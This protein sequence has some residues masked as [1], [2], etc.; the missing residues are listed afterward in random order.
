M[1]IEYFSEQGVHHIDTEGGKT[2][3]ITDAEHD[4]IMSD[5][6]ELIRRKSR[7]HPITF[8]DE[9]P[10]NLA[11]L[12]AMIAKIKHAKREERQGIAAASVCA[13]IAEKLSYNNYLQVGKHEDHLTGYWAAFRVEQASFDKIKWVNCGHGHTPE[14]AI[15]NAH[16]LG[17]GLE[18]ATPSSE[19]NR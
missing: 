2:F 4:A 12:E 8:V 19:F 14:E 3:R 13:I 9:T 17:Q 10:E 15:Y 11:F 5:M 1:R 16:R 18:C 7:V 6:D